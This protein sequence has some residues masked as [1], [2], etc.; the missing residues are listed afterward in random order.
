MSNCVW[1]NCAPGEISLTQGSR[2]R[3]VAERVG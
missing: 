3:S 1:R 2:E